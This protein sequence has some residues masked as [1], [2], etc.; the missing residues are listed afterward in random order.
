MSSQ[1]HES[2][3]DKGKTIQEQANGN[4]V[5][6]LRSSQEKAGGKRPQKP[7][8]TKLKTRAQEVKH[9]SKSE[10]H[11]LMAAQDKRAA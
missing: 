7:A 11:D 5:A 9:R 10:N 3:R 6:L 8:K 2:D 4:Q 1:R